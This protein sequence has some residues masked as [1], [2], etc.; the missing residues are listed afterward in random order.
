MLPKEIED[1]TKEELQ[2]LEWQN[3]SSQKVENI[4]I[5]S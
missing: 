2:T 5:I 4:T 1:E 3:T